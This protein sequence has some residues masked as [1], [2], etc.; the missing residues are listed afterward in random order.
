MKDLLN[1]ELN[2]GDRVIINQ[3]T[4]TG[5]S[6]HRKILKR[7]VVEKFTPKQIVT[8]IGYISPND[9]VKIF[10]EHNNPTPPLMLAIV[11]AAR[12]KAIME[13][14]RFRNYMEDVIDKALH[15]SS[16]NERFYDMLFDN[17][18]DRISYLKGEENE[19]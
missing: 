3:N 18:D 13:L 14:E 19:I 9:V 15:N 10:Y 2:I 6:T 17:I 4:L 8:N 5:S 7:A 1:N 12:S 11:D 16:C